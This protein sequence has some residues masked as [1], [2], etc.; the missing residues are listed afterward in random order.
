MVILYVSV[1]LST[2]NQ[3]FRPWSSTAFI[4]TW[5]QSN[6]MST[7]QEVCLLELNTLRLSTR[8]EIEYQTCLLMSILIVIPKLGIEFHTPY[9]ILQTKFTHSSI[10]TSP[11]QDVHHNQSMCYNYKSDLCVQGQGHRLWSHGNFVGNFLIILLIFISH[12]PSSVTR[13]CV[14][15]RPWSQATLIFLFLRQNFHISFK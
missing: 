10:F 6:V 11:S 13:W 14:A 8:L 2:R 5:H 1:V 3:W 4:M 12:G 15:Y 7:N 9:S